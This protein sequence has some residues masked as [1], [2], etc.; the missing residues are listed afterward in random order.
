MV[1]ALDEARR[2]LKPNGLL[3]DLRPGVVHRQAGILSGGRWRLIGVMRE[4]LDDDR[5]ANRAVRRVLQQG[6]LKRESRVQ[7][8]VLRVTDTLD[9]FR[10]LLETWPRH[11][12]LLK[13]LA[14]A[15]GDGRGRIKIALRGPLIMQVLRKIGD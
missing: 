6:G 9:E 15:L 10:A 14:G 2:V 1:H 4:S 12:W 3:I 11:D 7:F 13:R 5:A 8:E